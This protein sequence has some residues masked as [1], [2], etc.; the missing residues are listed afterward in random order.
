MEDGRIPKDILHGELA[1][2]KRPV[3]LL[4]ALQVRLL[5]RPESSGHHYREQGQFGG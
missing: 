5:V 1:F 4:A 3:G 2:G